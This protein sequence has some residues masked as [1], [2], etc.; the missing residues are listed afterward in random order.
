MFPLKCERGVCKEHF[1]IVSCEHRLKP[2]L[3]K[4]GKASSEDDDVLFMPK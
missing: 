2:V 1:D 4:T 3:R